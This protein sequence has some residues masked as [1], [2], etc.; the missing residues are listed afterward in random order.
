M[1]KTNERAQIEKRMATL[2]AQ[3]RAKKDEL[4]RMQSGWCEDRFQTIKLQQEIGAMQEH[5]TT[6]AQRLRHLTTI[7]EAPGRSTGIWV[8]SQ[9]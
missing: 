9:F 3:I 1:T 7:D 6:L 2:D 4:G 5:H 8:G